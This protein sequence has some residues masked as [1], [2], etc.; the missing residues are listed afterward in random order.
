MPSGEW[1]DAFSR[2]FTSLDAT[3]EPLPAVIDDGLTRCANGP[4]KVTNF[5]LTCDQNVAGGARIV[6]ENHLSVAN[7]NQC[8][9]RRAKAA[10]CDAFAFNAAEPDGMHCQLEGLGYQP[11][12]VSGWILGVR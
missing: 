5:K 10:N 1:T 7:I 11:R 9:A 6:G 12:P 2:D 8:A 4:V 3:S